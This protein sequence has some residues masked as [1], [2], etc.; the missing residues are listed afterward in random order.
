MKVNKLNYNELTCK[1]MSFGEIMNQT[2]HVGPDIVQKMLPYLHHTTL[3]RDQLLIPEGAR[4]NNM[5]VILEG[6]V[7][8]YFYNGERED[9]LWFATSGDW[10]C[11][12]RSYLHNCPAVSN[13]EALT[14]T[15]LAYIRHEDLEQLFS[16]SVELAN[17]GRIIAFE[18]LDALEWRHSQLTGGDAFSRYKAFLRMRPAE[19]ICQ[20]PQKYIASYL[21]ITPSTLSRIRLKLLKEDASSE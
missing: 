14:E 8:S 7:R 17:W 2:Y 9:T 6:L 4:N 10:F 18:E 5:Y 11:S 13:I 21:G 16:E 12:M 20:I 15:R 19:I 3:K 1:S